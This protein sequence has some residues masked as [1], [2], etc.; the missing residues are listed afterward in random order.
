MRKFIVTSFLGISSL[1]FFACGEN[2]SEKKSSLIEDNNTTSSTNTSSNNEVNTTEH[3]EPV[4]SQ[5]VVALWNASIKE[6]GKQSGKWK[7]SYK[8]GETLTLLGEETV[9]GKRTFLKVRTIEGKEGWTSDY[10]IA[11][12]A[13][14]GVITEDVIIYSKPTPIG[15]SKEK[16]KI[17]DFVAIYNE[18]MNGYH[19]FHGKEKKIKG[20]IKK[21]YSFNETDI[22]VAHFRQHILEEKDEERKQLLLQELEDNSDYQASPFYSIIL[23]E[24][25]PKEN[26]EPLPEEVITDPSEEQMTEVL[27]EAVDGTE[28]EIADPI[29]Y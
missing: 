3:N 17:G 12:D 23:A 21:G 14:F 19:E 16:L 20:W 22:E 6:E 8:Y 15:V 27:E 10:L 2:D 13:K 5:T 28:G 1:L 26:T 25:A 4:A 7:A 11:K 24:N 9:E 18:E 29:E